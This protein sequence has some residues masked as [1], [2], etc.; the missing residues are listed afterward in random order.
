[1]RFIG[2]ALLAGLLQPPTTVPPPTPPL[3]PGI[4][5][6]V[7]RVTSPS[8]DIAFDNPALQLK[9]TIAP[10]AAHRLQIV[11]IAIGETPIYAELSTFRLV[12]DAGDEFTPIAVGGRFDTLFPTARLPLDQEVGQILPSDAVFAVTR[13]G[14]ASVTL[15]AGPKATLAFLYDIPKDALPRSLKLPD[16]RVLR[17]D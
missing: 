9:G 14:E 17:L 4:D 3:E 11:E 5:A 13:H 8:A 12:S 16:G 7:T 1:V 15:E 6:R 2:F 10:T